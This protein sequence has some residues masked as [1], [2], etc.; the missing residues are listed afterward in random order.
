MAGS[1]LALLD[2]IATLL[3]DI[4]VISKVAAKKTAGV[5]GDDLAVNAEKVSGM[6]AAREIPV[7]WAVAKGSM[8]NKII[9]VPAIL[10]L[11]AFLP[12]LITPVL[13]AGG[14]YLCY[15]GAEAIWHAIRHRGSHSHASSEALMADP[16]ADLVQV[17]KEKIKGAIRTDFILSL[18]IIVISIS[19]MTHL[20]FL[21]QTLALVVIAV[22]MTVGVYGL[23][24]MIV[25]ID[26]LGLYLAKGKSMLQGLGRFLLWL[27]PALM[28]GLTIVGTAAMLLV[29][30]GIITHSVEHYLSHGASFAER[31]ATGS[32][33]LDA[34]LPI[35]MNGVLGLLIGLGVVAAVT[36]F[37]KKS[38]H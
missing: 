33:V 34:V 37:G 6:A 16:N 25:K 17:E 4:S 7:V 14:T 26:D 35:V 31:L 28:R 30:G 13:I 36:L 15:E 23:V 2:D 10:L 24:A 11:S 29:G 27:S 19:T 9:I 1:L 8:V 18:E 3:D 22:L 32:G 12:A 20:P 21:T 38:S 5:L